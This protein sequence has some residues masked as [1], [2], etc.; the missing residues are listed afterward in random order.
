VYMPVSMLS[1]ANRQ[2]IDSA[3]PNFSLQNRMSRK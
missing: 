3:N 1:T 2:Q